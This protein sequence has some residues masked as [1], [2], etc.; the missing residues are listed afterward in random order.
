MLGLL[1]GILGVGGTGGT[2]SSLG[3]GLTN[4]LN[5]D[6][7]LSLDS[8]TSTTHTANGSTTT[9]TVTHGLDAG[10]DLSA[11]LGTGVEVQD[12]GL[13]SGLLG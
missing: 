13:L 11:V 12:H 3:V 5:V 1:G 7:G 4:A 6:G 10:V 2:D 9:D 8:S